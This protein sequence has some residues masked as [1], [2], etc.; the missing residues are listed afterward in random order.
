[1]PNPDGRPR[2]PIEKR[3]WAQVHQTEACWIWTGATNHN[4]YGVICLGGGGGRQVRV[5]RLAY[6][7][8]VGPIPVGLLVLH[9][10]DNPSRVRPDHLFLGRVL[11]NTRDMVL[12][13]R[14][15]FRGE[16]N[17]RGKLSLTDVQEIRRLYTGGHVSLTKL[18][19]VFSVAK[20]H[21]WRIANGKAWANV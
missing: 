19:R 18:A 9:Q 16:K 3:F 11:D 2:M 1:M 17:G 6:E 14:D 8:L 21:V 7:L 20:G 15:G 12:K 10:C 4:G 13:G 5:H